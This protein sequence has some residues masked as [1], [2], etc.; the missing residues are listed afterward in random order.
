M[1][2]AKINNFNQMK[3]EYLTLLTI[4]FLLA[5][6]EYS[7]DEVYYVD[8]PQPQ[9]KEII[10]NLADY[11]TG[12]TLYIYKKTRLHYQLT[13]P[14]GE[15]LKQR[16]SL[17]GEEMYPMDD[18]L[19][20]EPVG[21]V[22]DTKKLTVDIEIDPQS[23][24][25]AGKLGLENYI[26]KFEYTIIFIPNVILHLNNIAHHRNKDDY[27][28]L[29]WD[30]PELDQYTV[31]KYRITYYHNRTEYVKEITDPY[32]TA[33]VD[34]LAV[35]GTLQ[36]RIETFFKEAIREPWV[37]IY[38]AVIEFPKNSIQ[39]EYTGVNSGKISWP[40]NEYR[41]KYAFAIDF[42]GEIVYEGT[43]NYFEIDN[44]IEFTQNKTNVFPFSHGGW[45]ELYIVPLNTDEIRRD[46]AWPIHYDVLYSPSLI[47]I[48]GGYLDFQISTDKP[49]NKLFIKNG[50]EFWVY[51]R[52]DLRLLDQATVE[53]LPDSWNSRA[54]CS[55]KSSRI[56]LTFDEWIELVS[57]DF[58]SREKVQFDTEEKLNYQEAFLGTNDVVYIKTY[59]DVVDILPGG[60][61]EFEGKLFAYSLDTRELI[62]YLILPNKNDYVAISRDGKYIAIYNEFYENSKV[63]VYQFSEEGFSLIYHEDFPKYGQISEPK[64]IYFNEKEPSLMIIT[65]NPGSSNSE[66]YV[67]NLIEGTKSA[68]R[69]VSYVCSDPYTGNIVTANGY[70]CTIYDQTFTKELF[71][72]ERTYVN[73]LF[74]NYFFTFAHGGVSK[75]YY[76]D[77][78]NY[79]KK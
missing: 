56:F 52:N 46:E 26:G 45:Y 17:D 51:D 53:A 39:F 31:D 77:I 12:A 72:Q 48:E 54:I 40:Q 21:N 6:C 1:R 62:N 70:N 57:Y 61:E 74:N 25:I 15:L 20:F 8:I 29:T 67:V 79:L 35:F 18:Y 73:H 43:E 38:T 13:L 4:L 55:E 66:T 19:E 10:V 78:T 76:L 59:L 24:S 60:I 69:L 32:K 23:E 22:R 11:P 75:L 7:R 63:S 36:Y 33:F 64:N 28:E 42:Y 5:A 71:A 27:F 34:T 16:F 47:T 3:I 14:E 68:K 9:D 49:E 37:D 58:K 2:G 44:M 65:L 41:S 30:K 50:K